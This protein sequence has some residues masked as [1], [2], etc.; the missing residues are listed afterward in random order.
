MKF[1]GFELVRILLF[2]NL[3]FVWVVYIVNGVGGLILVYYDQLLIEI[4]FFESILYFLRFIK[5]KSMRMYLVWLVFDVEVKKS[6]YFVFEFFNK[7]QGELG[8]K[9]VL[10]NLEGWLFEVFV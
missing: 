7:G 3:Y 1:L 10:F 5:F 9:F 2:Y 8:F 4:S 6:V